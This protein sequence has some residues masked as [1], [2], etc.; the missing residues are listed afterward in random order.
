[1]SF[2]A[3]V[4]ALAGITV[5]LTFQGGLL[6]EVPVKLFDKNGKIANTIKMGVDTGSYMSNMGSNHVKALGIDITKGSPAGLT[7]VSGAGLEAYINNIK[8]QVGELKPVTVPTIISVKPRSEAFLG[9]I[10]LLQKVKLEIFGGVAKPQFR[11]SELA[12]AAMANASAYFR[13]RV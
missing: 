3:Y 9:W 13:S 10:G 11:Y 4:S 6:P 2:T 12:Q 5:P 7:G 1:L 8:I